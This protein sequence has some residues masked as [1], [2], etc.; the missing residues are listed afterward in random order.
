[1]ARIDMKIKPAANRKEGHRLAGM[2]NI[3]RPVKYGGYAHFAG[4]VPNETC[5]TCDN[6]VSPM[7][8]KYERGKPIRVPKLYSVCAK[9]AEMRQETIDTAPKIDPLTAACK[10]WEAKEA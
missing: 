10:Y 6:C 3:G 2:G 4:A 5:R 1:M 9:W 7:E 8:T